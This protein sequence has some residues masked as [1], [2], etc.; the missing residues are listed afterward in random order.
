MKYIKNIP[1]RQLNEGDVSC[2]E[3][4]S[5]DELIRIIQWLI[6]ERLQQIKD[7]NWKNKGHRLVF[8]D[9]PDAW[10]TWLDYCD[11]RWPLPKDDD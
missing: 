7:T 10:E 5:R 9:H 3:E 1:L 4:K 11:T 6:R 2:L 8:R